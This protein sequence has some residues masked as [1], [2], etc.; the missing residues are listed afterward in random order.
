M[1]KLFLVMAISAFTISFS[2]KAIATPITCDWCSGDFWNSGF[3]CCMGAGCDP[4]G[5]ASVTQPV[6]TLPKDAIIGPR[7]KTL[8]KEGK[9]STSGRILQKPLSGAK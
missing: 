5:S 9:V 4:C 8:I 3:D 1:K 7:L 2:E 6:G